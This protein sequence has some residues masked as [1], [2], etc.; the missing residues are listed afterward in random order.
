MDG[1]YEGPDDD[2][3]QPSNGEET[4]PCKTAMVDSGGECPDPSLRGESSVEDDPSEPKDH[5]VDHRI[6]YSKIPPR[7]TSDTDH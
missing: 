6:Q 3:Y 1:E 4:N 2:E 5:I 7:I